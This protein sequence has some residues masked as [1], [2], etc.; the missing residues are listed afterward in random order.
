[1][2]VESFYINLL[3]SEPFVFVSISK[4]SEEMSNFL[5]IFIEEH[6]QPPAFSIFDSCEQVFKRLALLLNSSSL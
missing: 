6:G 3:C 2:Q 4:D 1:M 5:T